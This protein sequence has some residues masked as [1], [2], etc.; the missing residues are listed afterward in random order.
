MHANVHPECYPISEVAIRLHFLLGLIPSSSLNCLMLE[1]FLVLSFCLSLPSGFSPVLGKREW[2][3]TFD[4]HYHCPFHQ[5]T[6]T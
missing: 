1:C 6:F 4:F 3:R 2:S 5:F